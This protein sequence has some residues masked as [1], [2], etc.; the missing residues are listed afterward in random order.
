MDKE[1]VINQLRLAVIALSSPAEEQIKS[2]PAFVVVTDELLMDYDHWY[3]LAIRNYKDSF[4]EEQLK[5]LNELYVFMDGLP[6][7]DMTLSITDELRTDPFWEAFRLIARKALKILNW[8][9]DAL[10]E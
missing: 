2:F 10:L 1:V 6:E 3:I 4:T 9:V 5:I 8:S 7:E